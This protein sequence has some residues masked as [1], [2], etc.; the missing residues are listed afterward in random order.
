MASGATGITIR[1]IEPGDAGFVRE[2]CERHWGG[3]Q[4]WSLGR[5][6]P[7][8]ELPGFLALDDGTPAGF[9]TYFLQPGGYQC[10]VVTLSVRPEGRGVGTRL[11]EAAVGAA[12]GAGCSRV[13]L[14]TTNDNLRAIGFYQKRG[15]RLAALHK[16]FVDEARSR[17]PFIP[18]V[19]P[20][21]IAIHDEIEL[22]LWL[23]Q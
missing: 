13:F 8:D 12:H 22:E 19:G 16:G 6:Y 2:E 3:V 23:R 9:V 18:A 7:A 17:Y 5:M 4:I 10:E 14:T 20:S 21:G 11:L 15:W 1:P